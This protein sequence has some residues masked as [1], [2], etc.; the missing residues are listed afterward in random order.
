MNRQ[1]MAVDIRGLRQAL[2][3][4]P[5]STAAAILVAVGLEESGQAG[6]EFSPCQIPS[7]Q[8]DLTT[9]CSSS[10]GED[11]SVDG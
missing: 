3:R 1:N 2:S 8:Q 4:L 11:Q 7:H 9:H 6:T 5:A 10:S